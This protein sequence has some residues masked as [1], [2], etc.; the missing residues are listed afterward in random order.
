MYLEDNSL[1]G[2]VPE[3]VCDLRN[4]DNLI[5]FTTDCTGE[6]KELSCEC[7][8]NCVVHTKESEMG[9][10]QIALL[11]KL[12][13]VSGSEVLDQLNSVQRKAADW[14]MKEDT[15][16]LMASS[17]HL[18]QRY[19]LAIMY[20]MMGDEKWFTLDGEKNECQW[21]R[22]GCDA[23]GRVNHIKFDHCDMHGPIPKEISVFTE[24]E[25][26]DISANSISGNV[27]A[28]LAHMPMLKMLFLEHNDIVGTVP[29]ELCNRK[30]QGLLNAFTTD[31]GAKTNVLVQCPCCDNCVPGDLM[32]DE[33]KRKYDITET[34]KTLSHGVELI[35]NSPQSLAMK[36][37]INEDTQHLTVFSPR[38]TQR[39]VIAIIYYYL[40]GD[41]WINSFWLSPEQDECDIPGVKCNSVKRITELNFCK[42]QYS[43]SETSSICDPTF[44]LHRHTSY[45]TAN[46]GMSGRLP[47]EIAHLF[48]L[49]KIDFSDNDIEGSVPDHWM[50]LSNLCKFV[51]GKCKYFASSSLD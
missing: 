12:K 22:I 19:V 27:I 35:H 33:E 50:A 20:Y 49:S 48:E 38:F 7:C 31:C 6:S 42:Y 37:I 41:S 29:L 26:L 36:W 5:V 30:S 32:T 34:I 45:L 47:P 2:A 13:I 21:E 9:S 28:E 24:L 11:E 3:S 51:S 4:Q 18:S 8:T 17:E 25:F 43:M 16:M 1:V 15:M 10:R 14:I 39:Y 40:G 44:S 23:S 46:Q